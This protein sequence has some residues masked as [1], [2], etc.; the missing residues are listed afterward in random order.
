[1]DSEGT[2]E[3]SSIDLNL[4]IVNHPLVLIKGE[5]VGDGI[6]QTNGVSYSSAPAE[7]IQRFP[8]G[9]SRQE[10][11]D[12]TSGAVFHS[13]MNILPLSTVSIPDDENS[14]GSEIV[15]A[16]DVSSKSQKVDTGLNELA[17][18]KNQRPPDLVFKDSMLVCQ[19][20]PLGS[21]MSWPVSNQ[22]KAKVFVPLNT[23]EN[24]VTLKRAPVK[25]DKCTFKF[26]YEPLENKRYH[27]RKSFCQSC[28]SFIQEI[29]LIF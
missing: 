7:R 20:M 12:V 4:S 3:F 24:V 23:G 18:Y 5:L 17:I 1:M 16:D 2:N 14:N 13:R 6:L 11:V 27:F 25:D 10:V 26:L 22:G 21:S 8:A 29:C 9:E 19:S 28:S 15:K